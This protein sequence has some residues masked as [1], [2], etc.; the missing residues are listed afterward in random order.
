MKLQY[1]DDRS[2]PDVLM[3]ETV[4]ILLWAIEALVFLLFHP[5][6]YN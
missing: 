6:S 3:S 2:G 1:T 5:S 4:K